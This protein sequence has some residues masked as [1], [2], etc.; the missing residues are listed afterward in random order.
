[1]SEENTQAPAAEA[2]QPQAQAP[3]L[4]PEANAPPTDG[5]AKETEAQEQPEQQQTNPQGEGESEEQKASKNRE[6]FDRRFSDLSKRAREAE[7]RAARA[8][9]ELEAMRRMGSTRPEPSPQETKPQGPPNP[10]DF[11]QGKYDPDYAVAMAEYR[12]EQKL[13]A[14]RE[15]ASKR[16]SE[17]AEQREI[18]AGKARLSD[19]IEDAYAAAASNDGFANAPAFLDYAMRNVDRKTVDLI[20]GAENKVH[21]AEW[22]GRDPNRIREISALPLVQQAGAIARLDAQ[23]SFN[24]KAAKA[25]NGKSA[26]PAPAPKPAPQP[27]PAPIPT[28]NGTGAAPSFDPNKGS[29]D[30]Y[31]RW[32]NGSA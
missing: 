9:G 27:S 18:S 30:D 7:L 17:A 8:E 28:V 13:S 4:Q 24:M 10:D 23:I 32:R 1:M 21:V 15:A 14:E 11:G 2:A 25:A 19:A 29:M 16:E 6:R 12:M 26:Q 22:F 5:G 31:V 20:T 3:E